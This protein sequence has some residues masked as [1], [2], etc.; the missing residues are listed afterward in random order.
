MIADYQKDSITITPINSVKGLLLAKLSKT[1]EYVFNVNCSITDEIQ[2]PPDAYNHS[3]NQYHSTPIIKH[4]RDKQ[5]HY[6]HKILGVT[7]CDLFVPDVNFVF[8]QSYVNGTGSI[9]SLHRLR[10]GFYGK[11][12]N[13]DLF[14]ERITKEAIHE[15]GHAWGAWHCKKKRCI[16]SF[17][18]TIND[19][20]KKL[21]KFCRKCKKLFDKNIN[22]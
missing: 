21:F 20:D 19:T 6:S 22:N 17:S 13:V 11:T 7:E 12:N 2:M 4:L 15:L 1:L 9:I 3:R 10:E 16:M 8:G 18:T 14:H 5:V